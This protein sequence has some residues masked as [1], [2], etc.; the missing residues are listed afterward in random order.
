M[1]FAGDRV[2]DAN[3]L[4]L[5]KNLAVSKLIGV[6]I[7]ANSLFQFFTLCFN[8]TSSLEY[9]LCEKWIDM[10]KDRN[11]KIS[12]TYDVLIPL[13]FKCGIV[14]GRIRDGFLSVLLD[15]DSVLA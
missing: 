11:R 8:F 7:T 10:F 6:K 1:V 5:S 4:W 9:S 14:S 12:Q 2:R 15:Y 3:N 13:A